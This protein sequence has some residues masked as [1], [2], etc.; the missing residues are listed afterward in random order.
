MR[1]YKDI[2]LTARC[3][4]EE[5]V[6]RDLFGDIFSPYSSL[7]DRLLAT[8]ILLITLFAVALAIWL[9]FTLIDHVGVKATNTASV[10]IVQKKFIPEHTTHEIMPAGN[11][12]VPT[13][14]YHPD[15]YTLWFDI[16]G[17]ST[18]INVTRD[19]F[20]AVTVGDKVAV[21]YGHGR[22]TGSP[23]ARTVSPNK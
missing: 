15:Q 19:F 11:V 8:L 14:T 16:E 10:S 5:L 21:L 4:K 17:Y 2:I 20:D 6:F 9:G 18:C 12:M 1:A 3:N 7:T 22:L 23:I 13:T